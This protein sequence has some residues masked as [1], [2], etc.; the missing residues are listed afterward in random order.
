MHFQIQKERTHTHMVLPFR[1]GQ[2]DP[3]N[4]VFVAR[5]PAFLTG[6]QQGAK[7]F[8]QEYEQAASLKDLAL[9]EFYQNYLT[10]FDFDP[11]G[12]TGV[13]LGWM[14]KFL[15]SGLLPGIST[16]NV[17]FL[18]G[19]RDGALDWCTM[20]KEDLLTDVQFAEFLATL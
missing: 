5:H 7:L 17:D 20:K 13:V 18:I 3:K 9:L 1:R 8:Q 6:M 4:N 10:P 12:N 15:A 11:L 16:R 2:P 19:Y 14:R